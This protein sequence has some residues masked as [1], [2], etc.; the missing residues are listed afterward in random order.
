[1]ASAGAGLGFMRRRLAIVLPL[2]G[3]G[4]ILALYPLRV[5]S[6]ETQD[7]ILTRRIVRPGDT[8]QLGYLHSVAKSD[9]W[10]TFQIDS[11]GQIL[12]VESRFQGQAYGLPGG[13]EGKEQWTREGDWFRITGMRRVVSSI[14]WRIQSEW[15][16]RF[17]F[18]HESVVDVSAQ[19][20]S[21]LIH[22]QVEKAR[23]IDW[24]GFYLQRRLE[25]GRE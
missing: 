6:L 25:P 9:V 21:G 23:F 17:R 22:I 24:L 5:L 16:D 7:R 3:L 14:D 10:D 15:K 4:L 8:F 18:N 13:P 1:M 11:Q 20:G 12:L 2:I 19:V